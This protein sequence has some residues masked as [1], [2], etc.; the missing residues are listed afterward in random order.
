L[1]MTAVR[2]SVSD[3]YVHYTPW[4]NR[5]VTQNEYARAMALRVR[6]ERYQRLIASPINRVGREPGIQ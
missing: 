1:V 5:R 6:L 3:R 4:K 2:A